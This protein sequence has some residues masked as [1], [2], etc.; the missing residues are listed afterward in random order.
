MP[1]LYVRPDVWRRGFGRSLCTAGLERAVLDGFTTLTLWVL[2][3]N[4]RA[5]AFYESLGFSADDVAKADVGSVDR[6]LARR[7]RISLSGNTD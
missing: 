5:R 3:M 1:T 2:E 4:V 6:L 7:Y